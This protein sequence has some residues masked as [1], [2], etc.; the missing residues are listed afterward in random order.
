M[1]IVSHGLT[2]KV[3]LMR[4]FHW[5]VEE[6]EN[7]KTPQNCD[8]IKMKLCEDRYT[9]LTPLRKRTKHEC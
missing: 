5:S 2:I 7:Y 9:L 8:V 4:W 6:F 3:F 1:I